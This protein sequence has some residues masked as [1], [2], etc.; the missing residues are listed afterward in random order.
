M[1]TYT[2]A[3]FMAHVCSCGQPRSAHDADLGA[4]DVGMLYGYCEATSCPEFELASDHDHDFTLV[5]FACDEPNTLC[6]KVGCFT[7]SKCGQFRASEVA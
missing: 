6:S 1:K 4:H 2:H 5:C 7:C 3:E